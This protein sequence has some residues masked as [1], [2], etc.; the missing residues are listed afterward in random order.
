MKEL[1]PEPEIRFLNSTVLN[2]NLYFLIYIKQNGNLDAILIESLESLKISKSMMKRLFVNQIIAIFIITNKFAQIIFKIILVHV[3]YTYLYLI[4]HTFFYHA[5]NLRL[6][7]TPQITLLKP[8]L[9]WFHC[10][11]HRRQFKNI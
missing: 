6:A 8:T 9:H 3:S 5:T 7:N 4:A 11:V 2:T 1:E 10:T